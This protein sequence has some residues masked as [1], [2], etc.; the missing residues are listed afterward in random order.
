MRLKKMMN[1]S[2]KN[3]CKLLWVSCE[4]FVL[5]GY[6]W[7]HW[8]AK[9]CTT[10]A[11]RW[12]FRDAHPSRWTVWSAVIESPKFSARGTAVPVF[13]SA[14]SPRNLGSHADFVTFVLR[15]VSMETELA[16]YDSEADSREELAGASLWAGTLSH[17]KIAV[18]SSNLSGRSRNGFPR[19]VSLS[20]FFL[21]FL[22][23]HAT[24]SPILCYSNS[25]FL[26]V[27]DAM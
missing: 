18:N 23:V 26:F 8:V 20:L 24:A 22:L 7:I 14:K 9:S 19:T 25:H 17:Q 16:R 6:D 1:Y 2:P 13:F 4:V 5:Q 11:Y 15:E 10:T 12:L 21:R 27:R 3:F